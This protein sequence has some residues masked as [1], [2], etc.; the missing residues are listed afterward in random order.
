MDEVGG[1]VWGGGVIDRSQEGGRSFHFFSSKFVRGLE[2]S[3]FKT[4][5]GIDCDKEGCFTFFMI[6]RG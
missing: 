3:Y 6:L 1:A 2:S 4:L 5:N